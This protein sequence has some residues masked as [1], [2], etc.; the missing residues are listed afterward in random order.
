MKVFPSTIDLRT[1]ITTAII[2]LSALAFIFLVPS[3][4]HLLSFPVYMIEPMRV[5]LILS[6]AHSTQKN[7]YL[8]ALTLPLFSFLISGHPEVVKM[9]V[10][11]AELLLN[12]FLFYL[13]FNRVK[14]AFISMV[15][16]IIVSKV[17]C[18]FLYL[19]VFSWAFV[20]AESSAWFLAVQAVMIVVFSVYIYAIKGRRNAH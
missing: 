19:L 10:I 8:L 5:M 18:Y 17:F 20:K 3:V 11:T 12:V 1:V 15:T 6:L 16:S 2:D 9:A 13:F 7:S 4:A 14:N